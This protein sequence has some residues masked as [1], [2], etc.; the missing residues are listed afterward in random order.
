MTRFI[1]GHDRHQPSLLPPCVDDYVAPEALV[2]VV[3]AFVE[4]LD[5]AALGFAAPSR[6]R[7]DARA[8]ILATC[9]ASMCGAI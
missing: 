4:T 5:L 6:R 9:C 3:D 8:S 1:D 7:R 2:R